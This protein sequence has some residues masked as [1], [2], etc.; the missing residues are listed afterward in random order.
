MS[1]D[2]SGT[3]A[4][5]ADPADPV[6]LAAWAAGAGL[7]D[8]GT[9]LT[10]RRLSGGASNLTYRVTGGGRDWVLRRPPARGALPTAHDMAREFRVQAAL[11][12]SGVPVA[13]MAA[14]CE[15]AAV[16]GAPFYL[17]ERLD[18]VFHTD[19]AQVAAL[20]PAVAREAGLALARTLAALHRVDPQD[21]GLGDMVRAEP[22]L[23]RQL[24]R[25]RGQWDR[26][27][28]DEAPGLDGLLRDLGSAIP[29]AGPQG[30]VHGD[31]NF[32]NV[33]YR[34]G[35]PAE[36]RAVLDWELS[37]VGDPAADLGQL[38]AYWGPAGRL[39]NAHRGGH[40]PDANPALPS[41]AELVDAY[42]ETGGTPVRELAY[43]ERFAVVKLAVIC[44]GA[45]A[46]AKAPE[47]ERVRRTVGLV[48]DLAGIA[49]KIA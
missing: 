39:L 9:V 49:G 35:A 33:M 22:Y 4:D 11:A 6:R 36:V 3:T 12:G 27:G 13:R 23:S 40:L 43:Y 2:A 24:R 44:A 5:L 16:L 20:P 10:V 42:E 37:T 46:R 18:G 38:L 15:D 34:S 28:L 29:A 1:T 32:G 8:A 14:L 17:M 30:I 21:V 19:A 41:R 7:L 48:R 26:T 45:L 25:W 47:P 31:Y